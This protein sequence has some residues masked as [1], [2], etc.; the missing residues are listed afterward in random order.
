MGCGGVQ[1]QLTLLVAVL[2]QAVPQAG[3][4]QFD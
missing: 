2:L 1:T 4:A 3:S